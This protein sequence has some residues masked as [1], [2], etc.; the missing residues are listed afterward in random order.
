MFFF[1]FIII[2]KIK[3]GAKKKQF[4]G[5]HKFLA[6]GVTG[7]A[8]IWPHTLKNL[9]VWSVSLRIFCLNQKKKLC[10]FKVS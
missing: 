1:N 10:Y 9:F 3:G 5:K 6:D 2:H 4:L 8:K 7:G